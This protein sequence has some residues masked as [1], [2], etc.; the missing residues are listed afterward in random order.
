MYHKKMIVQPKYCDFV[1]I[2]AGM[3]AVNALAPSGGHGVV[4]ALA[5]PE[6]Q[7]TL[8]ESH[9]RMVG[10][11]THILSAA[12]IRETS[13]CSLRGASVGACYSEPA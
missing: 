5:Q 8:A 11:V 7:V 2:T 10:C 3:A 6:V 4:F 12:N 1:V 13:R 9:S